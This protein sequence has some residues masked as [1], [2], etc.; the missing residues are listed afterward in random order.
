MYWYRESG[1][2]ILERVSVTSYLKRGS[3]PRGRL[4]GEESSY[5]ADRDPYWLEMDFTSG[6]KSDSGCSVPVGLLDNASL[7]GQAIS[8]QSLA[9][10]SRC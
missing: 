3:L 9:P 8:C 5:G 1:R 4:E 2:V 10:R 7:C 6:G